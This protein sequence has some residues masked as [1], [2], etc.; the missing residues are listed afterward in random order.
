MSKLD[1]RH[2]EAFRL[3][4]PEYCRLFLPSLAPFI[5]FEKTHFLDRSLIYTGAWILARSLG[6]IMKNVQD[7]SK[8]TLL[9]SLAELSM[10]REDEEREEF[11]KILAE[12][13]QFKEKNVL[14]TL[15]EWYEEKWRDR[16][17]EE[18]RREGRK[19]GLK[20]GIEQGKLETARLMIKRGMPL[21]DILEITGLSLEKL[22]E[23]GIMDS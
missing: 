21:S 23:A 17:L 6:L 14:Q 19:T 1:L 2:R 12:D 8:R 13:P 11:Y 15:D 16:G 3:F 4:F 7:E 18:G 5:L 10:N 9:V 20:E 22:R